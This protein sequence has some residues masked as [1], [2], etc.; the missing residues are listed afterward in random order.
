MQCWHSGK[1][2]NA[3]FQSQ[4][5]SQG[6]LLPFPWSERER[7]TLENITLREG[8]ANSLHYSWLASPSLH[9]MFCHLPDSGRHVTS[10]FQGLSLSLSIPRGQERRGPWEWGCLNL[11]HLNSLLHSDFIFT[12]SCSLSC[13]RIN[14][15]N[16]I[17]DLVWFELSNIVMPI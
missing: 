3:L 2:N 13:K 5:H 7:E 12:N 17:L 9:V 11:F 4:L 6:P 15:T 8:L 1:S 14:I 16:I 10:I